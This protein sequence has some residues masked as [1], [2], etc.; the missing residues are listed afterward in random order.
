MGSNVGLEIPFFI[1]GLTTI[2]KRTYEIFLA[3]V[4]LNVDIKSLFFAIRLVAALERANEGP[5]LIVSLH[6][7][8][9]MTSCHEGLTTP[10]D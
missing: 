8:R 3:C 1:E 7:R 5:L 4:S 10:I 9:K 2:F 6:M